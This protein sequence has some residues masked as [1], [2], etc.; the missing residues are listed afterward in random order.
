M[1][2][3]SL[4]GRALMAAALCLTFTL[5]LT[6]CR[7]APAAAESMEQLAAQ[8]AK[9]G[10]VIW[11]GSEKRDQASKIVDA[12]HKDFPKVPLKHMRV[13][14]GVMA[15]KII[16]EAQTKART[17]DVGSCGGGSTYNMMKRDL[18]AK[19]DWPAVGIPKG[20]VRGNAVITAASIY[21]VVYN[22]NL[23]KPSEVP[24]TWQDLLNPRWKGKIGSWIVGAAF[25]HLAKAWGEEKVT[26][27]IEEFNKQKPFLFRSTYP[28]AQQVAAGEI[29]VALGIYHTA[30]PPIKAGAPVKVVVLNPTPVS[31]IFSFVT[32]PSQNKDGGKLLMRWL[33]SPK[34]A[35]IYE[36]ITYRGNPLT[37]STQTAQLLKGKNVTEFGLD[38]M[39]VA[40][41]LMTKFNKM[42]RSGGVQ[43]K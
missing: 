31:S 1:S 7:S 10:S 23:V 39:D 24:R 14:G 15:G 34:G 26:K 16:Q 29:P 12:Y 8:A 28:L 30:Q 13:T 20:L 42:V 32:T 2:K 4:V 6:V 25:V 35:K 41:K 22:T 38:E 27:Y 40:R 33:C 3:R 36:D 11:Y 37:P 21:A 18:L 9:G 17:A 43:K 5:A 19:V